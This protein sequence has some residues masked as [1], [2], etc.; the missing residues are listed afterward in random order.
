MKT[1][2]ESTSMRTKFT[3]LKL[4]YAGFALAMM[5]FSGCGVKESQSQASLKSEANY[6][7]TYVG[8]FDGESELNCNILGLASSQCESIA[9]ATHMLD[10]I[11]RVSALGA[12]AC[13]VVPE[14]VVTKALSITF[15]V[16]GFHTELLS[17]VLG[18]IPCDE[19]VDTATNTELENNLTAYLHSKN[20]IPA[21]EHVK[22]ISDGRH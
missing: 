8:L 22:I 11:T 10:N 14:P 20:L 7:P 9:R 13:A 4:P 12:I 15:A 1:T 17:F 2:Y 3:S 21:D 5:L 19:A 6:T 16:T 18:N